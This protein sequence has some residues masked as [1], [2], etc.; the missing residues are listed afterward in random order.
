MADSVCSEDC[1]ANLHSCVSVLRDKSNNLHGYSL[2]EKKKICD[3][4]LSTH[5]GNQDKER[6]AHMSPGTAG[7]QHLTSDVP[8]V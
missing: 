2:E 8:L 6:D 7:E 1:H 3:E 4:I 5:K